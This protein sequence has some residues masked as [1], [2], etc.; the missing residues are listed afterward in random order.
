MGV[1]HMPRPVLTPIPAWTSLGCLLLS[2]WGFPDRAHIHP[3]VPAGPSAHPRPQRLS[4]CSGKVWASQLADRALGRAQVLSRPPGAAG[5]PALAWL[6]VE[7]LAILLSL[8]LVTV[9]TDSC[10]LSIWWLSWAISMLGE[11]PSASPLPASSPGARPQTSLPLSPHRMIGGVPMGL[12]FGKIGY[13]LVLGWCCV[14]I[15]V[16]MVSWGSREG[17]PGHRPSES[18]GSPGSSKQGCQGGSLDLEL[19]LVN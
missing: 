9:N 2:G 17:E 8:Y 1:T 10:A 18:W 3:L 19:V 16:F 15:F 6:T 12:L 7:V 5:E 14:S 11:Y 13:Y 4:P